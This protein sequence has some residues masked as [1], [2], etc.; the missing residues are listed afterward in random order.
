MDTL[1]E[2]ALFAG[3]GGG[4]WASQQLGH[5]VVCYVER[6]PYCIEVLKAR[7]DDGSFPDAPI[8]D[9][10]FTFDGGPWRGR[11][12]LITAG[13]PCQPFSTASR[14]RRVAIDMWPDTMRII[15]EVSP[16][17]V[18]AENVDRKAIQRAADELSESGYVVGCARLSAASVG[19][20]HQRSRFWLL[21][22]HNDESKP[23]KPV[24]DEMASLPPTTR[25]EW[26]EAPPCGVLGMDDE[27]P[28]RSH[29]LKAL[30]NGQVPQCAVEAWRG[31]MRRHHA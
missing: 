9:D 20:P 18:F 27:L 23:A 31:L 25:P 14:G 30:G 13:F 12:D 5:R 4:V 7:I 17:W 3:A 26:R 2:I 8:W 21:A 28:G 1:T 11:V 24:H 22:H 16:S 10:V 6:E 19:A 15:R 29:R